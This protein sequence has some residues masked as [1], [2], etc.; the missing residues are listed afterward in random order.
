MEEGED[1]DMPSHE[2]DTV[3]QVRQIADE[4]AVTVRDAL[5]RNMIESGVHTMAAEEAQAVV[6]GSSGSG[7]ENKD[8][9]A[10]RR[11]KAYRGKEKVHDC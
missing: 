10:L 6:S 4:D 7:D 8:Q 11:Q 9:A 1:A 5:S 3:K 2:Q